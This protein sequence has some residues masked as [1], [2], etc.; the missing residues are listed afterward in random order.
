MD[1]QE[2]SPSARWSE[3]LRSHKARVEAEMSGDRTEYVRREPATRGATR[4]RAEYRPRSSY[5]VRGELTHL[6]QGVLMC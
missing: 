2:L 1:E 3:F 4:G 6:P 5:A